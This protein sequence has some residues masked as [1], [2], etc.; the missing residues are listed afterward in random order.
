VHLVASANNISY[1]KTIT[2]VSKGIGNK[3]FYCDSA[4]GE[5]LAWT[6]EP[7]AGG[8]GLAYNSFQ[9]AAGTALDPESLFRNSIGASRKASTLRLS[10]SQIAYLGDTNC[11]AGGFGY[12]NPAGANLME[13]QKRHQ[14]EMNLLWLDGHVSSNKGSTDFYGT[15]APLSQRPWFLRWNFYVDKSRNNP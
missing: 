3:L 15:W 9:V 12:G 14:G 4:A 1:D 8:K 2:M 6:W 7:M 11:S 13:L 10:L 5:N